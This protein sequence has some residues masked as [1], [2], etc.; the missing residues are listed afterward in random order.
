MYAYL[1]CSGAFLRF[2]QRSVKGFV[3]LVVLNICINNVMHRFIWADNDPGRS[4]SVEGI[5]QMPLNT[6]FQ[7]RFCTK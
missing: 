7:E 4:I 6:K 2:K 1:S 3:S 5:L